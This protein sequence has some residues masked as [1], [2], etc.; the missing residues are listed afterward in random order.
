[1]KIFSWNVR[2]LGW[3]MKRCAIKEVLGKVCLDFIIVQETKLEEVDRKIIKSYWS[4][5]YKGWTFLLSCGRLG[6]V[7]MQYKVKTLT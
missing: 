3:R 1:M 4:F 2:G 5:S 7:L 6:G